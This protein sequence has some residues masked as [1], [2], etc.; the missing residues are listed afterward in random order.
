MAKRQI[1][2][3]V[4]ANI[5]AAQSQIV[6]L[7]K[8]LENNKAAISALKKEQREKGKLDTE[9]AKRLKTLQ[10]E[11]RK[12][13]ELTKAEAK[14]LQ[15]L[16][17]KQREK[18]QIDDKAAKELATLQQRQRE[19]NGEMRNARRDLEQNTRATNS[20]AGS[21]DRLKARLAILTKEYNQLSRSERENTTRGRELQSQIRGISDELKRN[22]SAIG[23][24]R[25]EVGNYGSALSGLGGQMGSVVSQLAGGAGL[26]VA[27]A[28]VSAAI[29]ESIRLTIDYTL[30]LAKLQAISGATADEMKLLAAEN[31]RLGGSTEFTAT[32]VAE[33]Q[34]EL[35]KLGFT[36][37]QIVAATG[38]TLD[39]ASATGEDLARGGI[40]AASTIRAFG[41]EAS[42]TQHV[43]DVM[44]AS[45]SGSALDLEK[46]STAMRQ[47]GPV[48]QTFGFTVEDTTAF[49][50]TLA[51]AG[52]DASQA[53]TSLRNILLN[54]ADPNAKL[55][56]ALGTT[57]TNGEELTQALIRL[58]SRGV[59]L[60]ETLELT[61]K[62]SVAAFNRFLEGAEATQELSNKLNDAD[63]AAA[64][65]AATVRD[66]LSGDID[67]AT[68]ALQDMA[69]T[70][71]ESLEPAIRAIVKGFTEFVRLLSETFGPVINDATS[72]FQEFADNINA[73][74]SALGLT[75]N[76][77][78]IFR[79]IMQGFAKI[80]SLGIKTL[81]P[82]VNTFN[83]L[84]D[85][86]RAIKSLL[87]GTGDAVEKVVD[88]SQLAAI[89]AAKDRIQT[90]RNE[91]SAL[92]GA[93]DGDLNLDVS[94]PG[95]PKA[96]KPKT[97]TAKKDQK[98]KEEDKKKLE[99][100]QT[101]GKKE[102]SLID[103]IAKSAGKIRVDA[104]ADTEKQ[105]EKIRKQEIASEQAKYEALNSF[106]QLGLALSRDGGIAARV[107]ASAQAAINTYAGA[108]AAL[109]PPPVGAGPIVGPFVAAGIIAQ[110]LAQVANINSIKFAE[111]GYVSGPGT[112]TSDS[113]P[114]LLSNGESVINAR[115]T[116]M[117]APQLSAINQAGGGVPI[118]RR[119]ADGGLA[120][121]GNIQ[122]VRDQVD[123]QQSFERAL[124]K[125]PAPVVSVK[126]FAKVSNRVNVKET[127]G[128]L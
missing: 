7:T 15:S 61:D 101:Q 90:L 4:Q 110:G 77:F 65:M 119:F 12:K 75:N 125:M 99:D 46:F 51:N 128:R 44:A 17:Q 41:L 121:S 34:T 35:A 16:I 6:K 109:A 111:G 21:N 52:F 126:E 45:F 64:R 123:M 100:I 80:V 86:V 28:A 91:I 3:D 97:V 115:S 56:K 107:I 79:T 93:A 84:A 71:G 74:R 89:D 55:A 53:G 59:D 26:T 82:L 33:L 95:T 54:L 122:A 32:Q 105:L 11:L 29:T 108:A 1:I 10:T 58:R 62:R 92:Q 87:P 70:I 9:D 88:N 104:A 60:A 83:Q 116:A 31:R 102:L 39:L 73:V 66:T 18:A 94:T 76:E 42:D 114:A 120:T 38:A 78:S 117:F 20:A 112:G 127:T 48:A 2:L 57:A 24:N 14:E 19:L 49:L 63:G 36:T 50:G 23:D 96:K 103:Q 37:E 68:S 124:G 98:K 8:A 47:V 25:R 113:I 13:G 69:L 27:I 81:T 67:T 72:D 118:I 40:V 30:Q 43:V 22:E 106:A 5:G 85:T